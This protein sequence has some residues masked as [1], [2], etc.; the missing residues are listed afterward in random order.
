MQQHAIDNFKRV[1]VEVRT[2]VRV[3]EVSAERARLRGDRVYCMEWTVALMP[4][5]LCMHTA[6]WLCTLS[7]GCISLGRGHCCRVSKQT[8]IMSVRLPGPR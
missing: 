3:T 7:A 6:I 5:C 4:L 1:G 8:G 2:G